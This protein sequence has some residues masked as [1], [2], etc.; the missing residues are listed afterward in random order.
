MLCDDV[1]FLEKTG[2]NRRAHMIHDLMSPHKVVKISLRVIGYEHCKIV[3]P[4]TTMKIVIQYLLVHEDI[5]RYLIT[6]SA[7]LIVI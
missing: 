7:E 1:S 2:L 3:G 5:A 4:M 6:H